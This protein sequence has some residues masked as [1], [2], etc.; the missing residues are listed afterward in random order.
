MKVKKGFILRKLGKE[1]MVV[2]VGEAGKHFNG[3]IRM[4]ESG[5]WLWE[6]LKEGVSKQTLLDRMCQYYD[7]LPRDTAEADLGE[8]LDTIAMAIEE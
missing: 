8:F 1:Y 5:A 6:Q 4:N 3:M 2:A 7:D